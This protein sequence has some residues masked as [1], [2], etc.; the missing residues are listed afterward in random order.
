MAI[1]L[2]PMSRPE[3]TNSRQPNQDDGATHGLLTGYP[4]ARVT[5]ELPVIRP[6][7]AVATPETSVNAGQL[8]ERPWQT[9]R[10]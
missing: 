5:S 2:L 9:A 7:Y 10:V 8:L 6:E 4:A 3:S 1:L